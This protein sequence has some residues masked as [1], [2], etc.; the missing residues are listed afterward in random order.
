MFV[1]SKGIFL[2]NGGQVLLYQYTR[3]ET[4]IIQITIGVLVY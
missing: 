1:G 2:K 4:E 3:K